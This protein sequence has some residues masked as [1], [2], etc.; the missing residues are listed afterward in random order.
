MQ[1]HSGRR[2]LQGLGGRTDSNPPST[3]RCIDV[4]A[5]SS[6]YKEIALNLGVAAADIVFATD[7]LKE[8]QAAAAA[9]WQAVLVERPGNAP[10]PEG[11]GFRVVSNMNDLLQ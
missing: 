4:Q 2:P 7:I 10:L 11:H 3:H 8:A 6:S 1:L 9:G 5:E